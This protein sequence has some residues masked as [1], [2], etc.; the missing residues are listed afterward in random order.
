MTKRLMAALVCA[1][2]AFAIGGV[3]TAQAKVLPFKTA[4]TLAK[5]L[6][7]KQVRGRD[8]VSFHL[9]LP[10]RVGDSRIVF[11][12]D[13][14]T[15]SHVFCTALL[16][17]D[18]RVRGRFTTTSARFSGSS[19][20][21][22]PS[23]VLRFEAITRD[24]QRAVRANTLATLDRVD[25]LNRS[26][27]R[28]RSVPVPSSRTDE[29]NALFDIAL[30][31]ALEQPNDAAVGGFATRLLLVNAKNAT[32]RAG[33]AGWADYV[34]TVRA[35]PQVSDPCAS[36]KAWASDGFTSADAPVDFAAYRALDRRAAVDQRA[37]TRA[38][39]RMAAAGAFP[40]AVVGFTPK[41]LLEQLIARVGVTGGRQKVV[42]G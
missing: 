3:A 17:V 42:L 36:L 31:E 2:A 34:A 30:I 14:R 18:Q 33:A 22:I 26:A 37:I 19:C 24:A 12:Y 11:Q 29:A 38:A 6:A 27:R 25:A 21:G 5:R 8:V 35:L 40:N 4:K 13:D 20:H 28:C 9:L 41:G 32:L 23:E 10:R 1:L 7:N 15:A 39:R 16:I